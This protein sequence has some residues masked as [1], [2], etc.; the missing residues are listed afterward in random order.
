MKTIA[1]NRRCCVNSASIKWRMMKMSNEKRIKEIKDELAKIRDRC[2]MWLSSTDGSHGA[3]L[4]H[5]GF[6]ELKKELEELGGKDD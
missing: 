5:N 4:Y 1:R 6:G 2:K 3:C